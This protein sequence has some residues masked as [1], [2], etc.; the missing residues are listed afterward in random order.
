MQEV[1]YDAHISNLFN[2]FHSLS[3]FSNVPKSYTSQ[4]RFKGSIIGPVIH[5]AQTCW[6]SSYQTSRLWSLGE[7]FSNLIKRICHVINDGR[8]GQVG[9][10]F[11]D[12]W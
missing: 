12:T 3:Y 2:G 7:G 8:R 11:E 10:V 6:A 5:V 9:N 4:S 1:V